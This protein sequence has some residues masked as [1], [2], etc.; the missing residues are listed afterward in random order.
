MFFSKKENEKNNHKD[1][2]SKSREIKESLGTKLRKL[3]TGKSIDEQSLEELEEILLKADIGPTITQ[4]LINTL[5]KK[6]P[7]DIEAAIIILK[8]ELKSYLNEKPL[9][10]NENN[11]NIF[12]VLGV[13]GV[14][15]TTSIAKLANLYSNKGYKVMLAAGDTFRAAAIEQLSKWAEKLN[16]PIIK[17]KDN[18]DPSGVVF[19]AIDSAKAKKINLLI[20]DTAG[21]LHTKVNLIEELKKFERIIEKKENSVK[22][23]I[24]VIDATTGQN[25]YVQA[26]SFNNAIKVDGV[27]L[28]KYDSQAKGG[29]VFNIQKK[30][31][32]PFFFIGT[33]EKL[34]NI[35]EFNNEEFIENIFS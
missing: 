18:S 20:I 8:N 4:D 13:N 35:K 5:R 10:I 22:K 11:L 6:T 26:E 2:Y 25:A 17:Q 31:N 16:I 29:I 24:L 1:F 23:N 27:L 9:V 12:L 7:K 34:E 3:F 15:K 33:G 21:R 28:A 32:L 14:G 30:L 19:D